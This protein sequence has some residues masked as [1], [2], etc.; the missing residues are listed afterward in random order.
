MVVITSS[1][2]GRQ[3]QGTTFARVLKAT[4]TIFVV[5]PPKTGGIAALRMRRE[6]CEIVFGTEGAVRWCVNARR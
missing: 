3:S 2:L 1:L 6:A 4:G 5:C